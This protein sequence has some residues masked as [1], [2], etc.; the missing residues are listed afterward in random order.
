MNSSSLYLDDCE[1]KQS[2]STLGQIN[3]ASRST[4]TSSHTRQDI[5]ECD[6]S[7]CQAPCPG[8][9][10]TLF[11]GWTGLAPLKRG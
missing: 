10:I 2:I 8:L 3:V 1:T 9:F 11:I 7:K 5:L 4:G 6:R